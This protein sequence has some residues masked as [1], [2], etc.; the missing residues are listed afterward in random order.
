MDL[1]AV[2]AYAEMVRMVKKRKKEEVVWAASSQFLSL[3]LSLYLSR[4]ATSCEKYDG[5][6]NHLPLESLPSVMSTNPTYFI[7]S[8]CHVVSSVGMS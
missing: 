8:C 6:L 2:I 3:T 1:L 5:R 4:S 7:D